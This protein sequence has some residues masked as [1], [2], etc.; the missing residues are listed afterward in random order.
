MHEP[1]EAYHNRTI[2]LALRREWV[3]SLW[4]YRDHRR[5]GTA[6]SAPQKLL[7]LAFL[8]D[9]LGKWSERPQ[10]QKM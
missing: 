1:P 3:L 9:L 8:S 2:E 7:N 6:P 4:I 10:N 5:F